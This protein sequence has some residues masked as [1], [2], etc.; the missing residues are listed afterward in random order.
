MRRSETAKVILALVLFIV[1]AR[2]LVGQTLTSATIV[3]TV[4]DRAGAVIPNAAVRVTQDGSNAVSSAVTGSSGEYRFPFLKPGDY[5]ITAEGTGLATSSTHLHLLV[6][7][8]QAVNLT[9][10]LQSAQQSIEVDASQR[11]LQT[12]NGNRVSSYNQE[13]VKNIHCRG[14]GLGICGRMQVL[15]RQAYG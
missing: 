15:G 2:T 3:A 7:Q 4:T 5:T 14:Q 6:G 10:G 1:T 11:L 8:E 12:G 9:L 13:Y